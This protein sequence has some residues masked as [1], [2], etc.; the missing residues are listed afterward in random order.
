M[1]NYLIKD[2]KEFPWQTKHSLMLIGITQIRDLARL[3]LVDL[4]CIFGI[5]KKGIRLILEFCAEKGIQLSDKSY[6][7]THLR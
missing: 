3:S 4:K 5:G 1:E 7:F 2:V 6:F